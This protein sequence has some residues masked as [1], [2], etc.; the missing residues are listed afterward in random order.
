MEAVVAAYEMAPSVLQE[1]F[2]EDDINEIECSPGTL[3]FIPKSLAED[4]PISTG[5]G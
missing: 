2:T 5:Y 4:E 1:W 3:L